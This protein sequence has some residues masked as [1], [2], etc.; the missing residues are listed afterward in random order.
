MSNHRYASLLGWGGVAVLVGWTAF[1]AA[2]QPA[3][4]VPVAVTVGGLTRAELAGVRVWSLSPIG[5]VEVRADDGRWVLGGDWSMKFKVFVPPDR[6][7]RVTD[8]RADVGG[9]TFAFPGEKLRQRPTTPDDPEHVGPPGLV[10]YELPDEVRTPK[11]VV[12]RFADFVNWPGDAAVGRRLALTV[13]L[14]WAVV[15]GLVRL[16]RRHGLTPGLAPLAADPG[17]G[18]G[19]GLWPIRGWDWVG[20]GC[21][22]AGLALL[23]WHEPYYFTQ[24]DVWAAELPGKVLAFRSVWA[25]VFPAYCPYLYLGGGPFAAGGTTEITYPPAHLAFA[26]ARH[27][28]G[29]DFLFAEVSGC[30][31][32]AAGYV[33]TRIL[34]GRV[35]LGRLPA[36]LVALAFVFSGSI[37][38]MGRSWSS[39]VPNAV[40]L[41]ALMLAVTIWAEGPVGLRW[42]LGTGA[43]IGAFFQVGFT[44]NPAFGCGFL[45]VACYVLVRAGRV[46]QR[47]LRAVLAALLVGGGLAAPV[48]YQQMQLMQKS[49]RLGHA[50]GDVISLLPGMFLPYPV[51]RADHPMG[52]PLDPATPDI[53]RARM[54][55]FGFFGGLFPVLVVAE[56]LALAVARPRSGAAWGGR[57]WLICAGVAFVLCL[58]RYGV[59]WT[60]GTTLPVVGPLFRY[61]FRVLPDLVLFTVL[62]GG[63]GLERLLAARVNRRA[64][65]LVVA[66]PAFGLLGWHVWNAT[67]AFH[68][69][70]CEPYPPLAAELEPA[71]RDA[72]AGRA[73][74][75][76]VTS[77]RARGLGYARTLPQNLPLNHDLFTVD[78]YSPAIHETEFSEKVF[79]DLLRDPAGTARAYAIRWVVEPVGGPPADPALEHRSAAVAAALRPFLEVRAVGDVKVSELPGTSPLGF[80]SGRPSEGLPVNVGVHGIDIDTATVPAGDA[81][82]AAFLWLPQL[83]AYADGQ[84]VPCEADDRGRLRVRLPGPTSRLAIRYESGWP[85]GIARGVAL[86]LAGIAVGAVFTRRSTIVDEPRGSV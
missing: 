25:G 44:S 10:D 31:H 73:R 61:P 1:V 84:P 62:A 2:V 35:G 86:V 14:P 59:V 49:T 45:V 16:G 60:A 21:V 83:R 42:V 4:A 19:P 76:T 20:L 30:L 51:V 53:D 66:V 34:A 22:A 38:I 6:A 9:R 8:I 50:D 52:W 3:G 18:R 12:P 15:I 75:L 48:L 57:V 69:Y 24:D 54:G 37:L 33:V 79:A 36:V 26:I 85:K 71:A 23:E 56:V 47:R 80:A 63:S 70:D 67:P 13:F 65:E 27:G 41:P 29:E 46:P 55:H 7:G 68:K 64:W 5:W 72:A 78:G 40:W 58:G 39:F 11:S 17:T 28:F 77:F 81:V 82:T 43:T 32:V 74:L